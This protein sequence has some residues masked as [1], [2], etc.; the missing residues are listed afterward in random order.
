M[1]NSDQS[2]ANCQVTVALE[3]DEEDREV[4]ASGLWRS[5]STGWLCWQVQETF[6]LH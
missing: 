2:S 4:F 3:W 1:V 5:L 6:N